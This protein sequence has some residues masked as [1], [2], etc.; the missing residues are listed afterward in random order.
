MR[1]SVVI[2]AYDEEIRLAPTLPR[3]LEWAGPDGEVIVVDDGSRDGTSEVARRGGARVL[4]A[5]RNRGKGHAVRVGIAAAEGDV[6]V[7]T[8]ADLASPIDQADLLL[9]ALARGAEIA[10]GVRR[11]V[12]RNQPRH[13]LVLGRIYGRFVRRALQ[14]DVRDP[15]CG[16][17]AFCRAT[18]H[19]L[20]SECA[21][22]GY[23]FDAEILSLAL[24]RGI[25][26]AQVP[27]LWTDVPGTKVNVLW[28]GAK[29]V[30]DVLGLAARQRIADLPERLPT[31]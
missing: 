13:R 29:M 1:R 24:R 25:P 8:D 12:G 17:K 23:A 28:D 3:A 11:R 27:V 15:Q 26:V 5:L 19:A 4:R 6:I 2:P 22:D 7:V 31:R 9:D 30:L 10:I 16:M 21:L 20:A 14:I 18:A